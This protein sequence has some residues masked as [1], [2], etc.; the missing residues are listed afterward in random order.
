MAAILQTGKLGP[1]PATQRMGRKFPRPLVLLARNGPDICLIGKSSGNGIY[2]RS[3][4][5]EKS[6]KPDL[7]SFSV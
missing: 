2:G 5:K 3:T 4:E 6:C 7:P 1:K